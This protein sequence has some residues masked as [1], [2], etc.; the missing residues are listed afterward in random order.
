MLGAAG[1]AGLR[2]G[3][4]G[5]DL[6]SWLAASW[7]AAQQPSAASRPHLAARIIAGVTL[8]ARLI[9]TVVPCTRLPTER[10]AHTAGIGGGMS[11][12]SCPLCLRPFR[13]TA[14][15]RQRISAEYLTCPP[16]AD[17]T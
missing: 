13:H 2:G 7:K 5:S 4:G 10:V 8:A 16:K 1:A 15:H 9:L 12:C 11:Q 17:P 14:S 6:Q 3:Q